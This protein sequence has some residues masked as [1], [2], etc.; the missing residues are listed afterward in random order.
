[1]NER[2]RNMSPEER[3]ERAR[4]LKGPNISCLGLFFRRFKILEKRIWTKRSK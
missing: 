2:Y 3:R 4:L 1:M